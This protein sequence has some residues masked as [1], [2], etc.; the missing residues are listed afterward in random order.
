M[1]TRHLTVIIGPPQTGKTICA[2][3]IESR[4]VSEG[5]RVLRL[6]SPNKRHTHEIGQWCDGNKLD[7]LPF[8]NEP[9][10]LSQITHVIIDAPEH[11]I[12]QLV[13]RANVVVQTSA[14]G[15]RN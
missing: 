13:T 11:C 8:T 6:I 9:H 15:Q 2:E 10:P 4:L 1:T 12:K 5:H 3:A 14:Y 7:S